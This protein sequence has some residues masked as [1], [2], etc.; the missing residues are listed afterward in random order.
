M[1]FPK[2]FFTIIVLTVLTV[3]TSHFAFGQSVSDSE[4]KAK[5]DEIKQLEAKVAELQNQGK[6]LSLQISVMNNQIKLTELRIESTKQLIAKLGEDVGILSG[7]IDSLEGRLKEVSAILL[8]RIVVSYKVGNVDPMQML[9]TSNGF[10]DFVSQAKYIEVAQD[11]DRKLLFELE[12]TKINYNNQKDILKTKQAQQEQLQAQMVKLSADLAQ[13][14]QDKE[15]LLAVTKNDEK[16]YS[17]L[18]AKARSEFEAIQGIIAGRGKETE[19]GSVSEGQKIASI[20]SGASCN[21]GG[22]HLH[23]IVSN[24]GIAQN[25]FGYLKS[26]IDFENCSGSS[27]GSSDGDSFAPTGSWNWPIE[28]KIRMNQGYGSTWATR[29]DPII[30]QIYSFHNGIDIAGSS[31]D[32]K[33][34]KAGTLFR[35]SYAGSNGCNLRYVRV[36]HSDGGLDTFY[37]HINYL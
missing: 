23:F 35:G 25:P 16:R 19:V 33:A 1:R 15:R 4:L 8:N 6:S 9:F 11:N 10:S 13:Q 7:K 34:V 20:I 21:S 31:L 2:L 3:F 17:D 24:N 28:P 37:L 30:R 26:G 29:N 27:C 32:V 12:Q 14:K 22:T 36:H 18:L 5:E